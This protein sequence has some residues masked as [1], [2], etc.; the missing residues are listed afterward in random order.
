[1]S[2]GVDQ[3][4]PR[5]ERLTAG[6]DYRR[7]F[8][9]GRRLDGALFTL[10]AAQNGRD[11]WRLGLAASRRLGDATRRNRA[12]R[13][14]R[15]SFRRCRPGGGACFD[16]VVIPKAEIVRRNQGEVEREYRERLQRLAT[17]RPARGRGPAPAA[18]R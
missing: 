12:K 15:E 10:I 16:L 8:R 4:F 18:G 3:G 13:L 1:V 6:A 9:K 7:V 11:H 5:R 2:G 14:L 17:G